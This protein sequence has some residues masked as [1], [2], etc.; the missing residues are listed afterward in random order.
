MNKEKIN[1]QN[2]VKKLSLKNDVVF[3]ELFS[4]KGNEIFLK[5][6]LS[7]LLN[8]N[9]KKIEIQ[10]DASLTREIVSE[11]FGILDIKATLDNEKIVDIEM[12]M[13]DC[14]DMLDRA[15]YYSSKLISSQLISGDEYKK[16]KPVIVIVIL[17]F[18]LLAFDEYITE[19]L[20]VS[21]EHP[22][23]ELIDKLKM[24]FIELPKF[25]KKKCDIEK[26]TDQWLVFIDGENEKGVKEVMEKNKVIKKADKEL[27]YLT[28]DE[29]V[30]WL[31]EYRER[32]LKE[33]NSFYNSTLREGREKG[34]RE[35]MKEGMKE[36]IKEGIKEEKFNIAKKMLEKKYTPEQIA[37]ITSL[38]IDEIKN[39]K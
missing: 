21:K 1:E 5:D 28:G 25:R 3:K 27:E 34:I 24:Y 18:N 7:D 9:I 11:K 12:Q 30:R 32:A 23:Y 26:K 14:K 39:I 8:I 10:K 2:E 6:F 31:A 22:N 15:L 29:E 4:K 37:D 36:G 35:G 13:S 16:L 33:K 38:S 17:N 20:I 19:T